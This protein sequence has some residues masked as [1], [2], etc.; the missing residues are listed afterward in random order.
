[1]TAQQK[2]LHFSPAEFDR[3]MRATLDSMAKEKLD[4]LLI[5]R[6]ESMF[7]LSGF[8][9]FGYC[10]FQCLYLSA[11]G[12]MKLLTRRPDFRLAHFTSIIPD[13]RIWKDSEHANPAGDL[14][15][16]LAEANC[17]GKTLGIELEAYGLTARNGR[18]VDEA[19][20]GWCRLVDASFLISRLRLVKSEE[21]LVYVRKAAE[22]A[23]LA[24]EEIYRLARPG[25]W[26]G[27]ILAGFQG[28]VFRHGGDFSG[29]EPIFSSG[30]GS[31]M[32]RYFTGRRHIDQNDELN[33]EF[34][35]VY[36]HYHAC[37]QRVI[38]IGT[39]IQAQID[40]HNVAVDALHACQEA[41]QVGRPLG[42]IFKAFYKAVADAGHGELANMYSTGY[43]LGATYTPTWMDYPLLYADNPIVIEPNMV[44][45]LHMNLRDDKRGFN[46]IPAETIVTKERGCERLSKASLHFRVNS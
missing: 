38:R 32:G 29:N 13:I 37:I 10:F 20:E 34:A 19:L 6:Q 46:A 26:E 5:F 40:L 33:A 36:R 7:W 17:Q 42:D 23:D 45:F 4:G 18:R 27:D 1:M 41:A 25:A 22:I 2:H 12:D 35:G 28:L 21:E 3:R 15:A 24:L 9:T 14:K 16:M 11:D 8:D 43:S 30:P 44:L 39:P 31:F